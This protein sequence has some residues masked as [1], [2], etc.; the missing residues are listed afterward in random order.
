MSCPVFPT[1]PTT[2]PDTS[3]SGIESALEKLAKN[4]DRW[5]TLG[6]S[7]KLPF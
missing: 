1:P 6:I 7:E 4:K 3:T 5:V 2:I